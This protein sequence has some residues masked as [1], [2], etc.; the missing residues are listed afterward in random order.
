MKFAKWFTVFARNVTGKK[1]K[2]FIAPQVMY[3]MTMN[4]EDSD[5]V[6]IIIGENRDRAERIVIL[7]HEIL[8]VLGAVSH[9]N[10]DMSMR[11]LMKIAANFF[12]VSEDELIERYLKMEREVGR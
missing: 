12:G 11:S 9:E 8:H 6:V 10:F 1:V 3:G 4:D 7:C 5:N 2:V